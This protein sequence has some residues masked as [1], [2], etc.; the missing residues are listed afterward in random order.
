MRKA[1]QI[2]TVSFGSSQ[3]SQVLEAM[4]KGL[5]DRLTAQRCV[6]NLSRLFRVFLLATLNSGHADVCVCLF[7]FMHIVIQN[8]LVYLFVS[9]GVKN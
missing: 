3:L 6:L 9:C 1:R 2:A 5:P 7:N 8:V 4:V